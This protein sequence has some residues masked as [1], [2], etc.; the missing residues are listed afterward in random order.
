MIRL[1]S[2]GMMLSPN[3]QRHDSPSQFISKSDANV[4]SR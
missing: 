3:S 1:I 2:A 4:A